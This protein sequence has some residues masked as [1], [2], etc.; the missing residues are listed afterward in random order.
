MRPSS[1]VLLAEG[2]IEDDVFVVERSRDSTATSIPV[3]HIAD[4]TGC[5]SSSRDS[6]SKLGNVLVI[7]GGSGYNALVGVTPGA[8]FVMPVS[9]NG[10]SSSEII[11]VLGGPS[12]GDLR[13][14]LVRLIPLSTDQGLERPPPASNDALHS[15]LSYRLPS[16]GRSRDI[17]QEWMDILEGRHHL[18]RGIEAERKEVVRGFLVYFE[19]EILRRAHRN[20]NF[21][22]GSIGNFF[23]A[24]AQRFFRSIQSAIFLFST[25]TLINTTQAG[26]VL[27]VINTNHSATIAV[28]LED[29]QR[30]LGQC[31]ISHPTRPSYT[32]ETAPTSGIDTPASA[33]FD[34][35]QSL[36][37]VTVGSRGDGLEP[38]PDM[39]IDEDDSSVADDDD[40]EQDS[41]GE[42]GSGQ[43]TRAR[44]GNIVF[45]KQGAE[46]RLPSRIDRLFYVNA[47]GH[48]VH[49]TPNPEYINSIYHTKTLLY[50]CGSLW[51]SI[52]PCLALRGVA[53]AITTSPSLRYKVL[54]LNTIPDR[55][56]F[57]LN[58]VDFVKVIARAMSHSDGRETVPLSQAVTHVI[59]SPEGRIPLDVDILSKLGV[60][61]VAVHLSPNHLYFSEEQV[62]K[63]LESIVQSSSIP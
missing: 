28:S 62:R 33:I 5:S 6:D 12:L 24:A 40:D 38:D 8:T 13:S 35:F 47:Y 29:G 54:L 42:E 61:S 44:V 39:D 14:R 32:L 34:P 31:E 27:P 58:G 45:T 17:K 41:K 37:R 10:G 15:L 25:T 53:T 26:R 11:R 60:R 30:I 16:K 56:T 19:S 51:T 22:G 23:L 49:P 52:I 59:Y 50:S 1:P 7:S 9:D 4:A 46:D 55:E 18:W 21:R 2:E 48:E 3:V 36:S 20:F 43:H 63:A 57:G